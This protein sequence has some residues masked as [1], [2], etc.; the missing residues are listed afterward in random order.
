VIKFG[1]FLTPATL[2]FVVAGAA[3][4]SG[5]TGWAQTLTIGTRSEMTLDPH[6]LWST[7]NRAYNVQLYGSLV[8]LD[9]RLRPLPMLA[10]GWKLVNETT[11]EFKLNSNA[12]F[13]N[14]KPVEADDVVASFERAQ[15]LPN[16]AASYRG[17][18]SEIVSVQR[19]DAH[20]VRFV[21]AKPDPALLHRVAQIAIIPRE[22]ARTASQADF[23]AGRSA[24]GAGPYRF[25]SFQAGD[26]LVLA[27]NDQYFGERPQWEKV[28]FRTIT[29]DAARV[30]ALLGRDVDLIDLVPP[31]DISR[32]TSDPGIIVHTG[33]SDR[34]MYI[35]PDTGRS[36]SP[37]VRDADGRPLERN[38]MQDVRVRRAM[39]LAIDRRVLVDRVMDGAGEPANQTVAVGV[40]GYA[41]D[42]P[43][44]KF[45]LEQAK[46]LLA[47]AGYP[48]GFGLTIHCSNDRYI[49]DAR[50]CQALGQMLSRL[51]L[52]MEVQTLP[53]AVLFPRITRQDG[54]GTSLMLLAFGS[55]T[56]GDAGGILNN[57]IHSFD[58]GKGLGAWNVG[59]YSNP[60]IDQLI[61]GAGTMLDATRRG[62]AQANA[63]ALAMQDVAVIPLFH[64]Q[65]IFASRKGIRYRIYADESTLADA[66]SR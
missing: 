55:G 44:S 22:I 34:T 40:L 46:R 50:L 38:P 43:A 47:D 4:G 45:D 13:H 1:R 65:V 8:R 36:R 24:V 21:T 35:V 27:R 14:G 49:N 48:K 62:S 26:R 7:P 54:E 37:F 63:I 57:T 59:H 60:Q 17:A 6:F 25:V 20:T 11:W 30:A 42:L 15:T 41:K 61:E 52:Q 16:A 12:R 29:D 53:R 39:S 10:T 64:S 32:L 9:D 5:T 56:T 2:G 51:G 18:L 23:I 58:R 28:V 3:L 66:A 33:T 19:I 31:R